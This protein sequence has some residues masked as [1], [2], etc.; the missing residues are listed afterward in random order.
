VRATEQDLEHIEQAV[1]KLNWKPPQV[2]IESKFVELSEEESRGLGFDFGLDDTMTFNGVAGF[3]FEVLPPAAVDAIERFRGEIK[4]KATPAAINGIMSDTQFRLAINVLEQRTSEDI[5][6]APR[7]SLLSG[8]QAHISS[9]NGDQGVT[10]D[11]FPI[12]EP[13]GFAIQ[14]TVIG[15]IKEDNHALALTAS[16]KLWDG[17]TLVFGGMMADQIPGPKKVL[18]V[19]VTPTIID[20]AG[21][22]VHADDDI[23][24]AANSIPLQ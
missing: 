4:S 12:V 24:F 19:F 8:T 5:L 7:V 3:H 18:L 10:L 1:E 21:N 9:M 20:A 16:A 15:S 6:A 23:P 14:T 2:V 22:K 13:D 17:Q 11:V